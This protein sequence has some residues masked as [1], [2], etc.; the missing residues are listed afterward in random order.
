MI[1]KSFF[2]VWPDG[3]RIQVSFTTVGGPIIAKDI[4]ENTSFKKKIDELADF[5]YL[6]KLN[7]DVLKRLSE[8]KFQV[9]PLE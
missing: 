5:F 1:E 9:I 4:A 2:K 8:E 3:S 6:K 7:D